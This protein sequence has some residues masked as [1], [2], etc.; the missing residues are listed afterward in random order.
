MNERASQEGTPEF[1]DTPDRQDAP[2]CQD[3]PERRPAYRGLIE[4]AIY[5][6][7]FTILRT[8]VIAAYKIP[9]ESMEDTLLVGDFLICNQF[10]YGAKIPFTDSRLPAYR[11]PEAGDVV[12][13]YFPGDGVTRYIKRCVAVGGDTVEVR[14]KKLFVNGVESPMPETGKYVDRTPQG[15]V[16]MVKGRDSFGPV[17]VPRRSFFMMGD[18]RDKSYDSRFWG[19]V[20]YELIVGKAEAVHWSWDNSAAPTPEISLA[21]PLSVPRSYLHEIAH[22]FE[23]ARFERILRTID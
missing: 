18:N 15:W 14:Q 6:A 2:E 19:P 3:A 16:R 11:E 9:S 12:V 13:F 17:V 20:P 1:Q 8:S 23:K 5:L 4:L 7:L 10:I 21:D 22:F